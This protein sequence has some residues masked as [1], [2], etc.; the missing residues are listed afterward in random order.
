MRPFALALALLLGA[1]AQAAAQA[2]GEHFT[3]AD[4]LRGSLTAPARTWWDVTYYDLAVRVSPADSTISGR[5][6]ITYRVVHQPA[7]EMQIDLQ[8]PLV[9]DSMIQDGHAVRYRRDG[10]AFFATTTAGQAVGSTNTITVYYH[11]K[12]RVAKRPPWDGGFIFVQDSLG[13]PWVATAVQGLG[14]SA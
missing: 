13:R 11:G 2:Q 4:S 8:Q 9:V 3:H 7:P 10:N 5:T 1:S 14:A 12:P 6:G